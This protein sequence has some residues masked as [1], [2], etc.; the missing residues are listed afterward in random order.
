LML[1][2]FDSRVPCV[3]MACMPRCAHGACAGVCPCVVCWRARASPRI[4]CTLRAR[5]CCAACAGSVVCLCVVCCRGAMGAH[6]CIVARRH[7]VTQYIC[8]MYIARG[9]EMRQMGRIRGKSSFSD[10]NTIGSI[11]RA[12]EGDACECEQRNSFVGDTRRQPVQSL[13]LDVNSAQTM[14]VEH[15]ASVLRGK[16]R[17]HLHVPFP[18]ISLHVPFPH[19]SRRSTKTLAFATIAIGL[20]Y[21]SFSGGAS[22]ESTIDGLAFPQSIRIGGSTQKLVGGGTRFKYGAVKVRPPRCV[23]LVTDA[24]YPG[25][26]RTAVV[27]TFAP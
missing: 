24:P 13:H 22:G 8:A 10:V 3:C 25:S 7:Y 14:R 16:G 2:C 5:V 26:R 11:F 20:G 21:Y 6:G 1:R 9:L 17:L 12:F 23:G 19:T 4:L 15:S 18:H 27:S